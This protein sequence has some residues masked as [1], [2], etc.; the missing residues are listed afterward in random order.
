VSNVPATVDAQVTSFEDTTILDGASFIYAVSAYDD[1]STPNEGQQSDDLAVKT[2]PSVPQNLQTTSGDAVI[3]ITF[4]SVKDG[5]NAKVNE[6]LGGY[7]IY[8]KLS[9]DGGA[10]TFL[11]QLT[12]DVNLHDDTTVVN[13][14]EYSYVVTAIDNSL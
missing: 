8:R 6:N 14:E 3:R 4:D 1:E 7:R 2:I 12:G 10:H 13:G 5:G 9:S 11:V